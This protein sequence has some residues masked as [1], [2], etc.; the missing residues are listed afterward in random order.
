MR[1]S[2]KRLLAVALLYCCCI[3]ILSTRGLIST[4]DYLH[5]LLHYSSAAMQD[6]IW[7]FGYELLVEISKSFNV[8]AET[9]L[10]TVSSAAVLFKLLVYAKY[11]A[12]LFS[13][14]A[15]YFG[16]FF[17]LHDMIQ[18]RLALAQPVVL[19]AAIM[20]VRRSYILA[21]LAI[22]FAAQL[23]MS[24]WL[25]LLL[26]FAVPAFS[27]KYVCIV[28]FF[29]AFSLRMF[30]GDIAAIFRNE[31]V[32]SSSSK[33][34]FY[35][36]DSAWS[37]MDVNLITSISLLTFGVILL[38]W[39]ESYFNNSIWVHDSFRRI[40]IVAAAFYLA[41]LF[42]FQHSFPILAVRGSEFFGLFLPLA[43]ALAMR[44][45]TSNLRLLFAALS[46]VLLLL[47]TLFRHQLLF[48]F[49]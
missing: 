44:R 29:F 23:H 43:F 40:C 1:V 26:F 48:A 42:T 5:Y 4:R 33:L 37:R 19:L 30:F 34:V 2:N 25:A 35:F 31:F 11:S 16:L 14:V 22:F 41:F 9:F 8:S 13:S 27:L 6:R 49:G 7:E 15:I 3:A 36:T 10:L 20:I 12:S 39:K 28:L 32:P 21:L 38:L 18:L 45:F 24:S 46:G 17:W 47:N